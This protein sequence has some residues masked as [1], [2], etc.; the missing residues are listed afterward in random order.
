M[1]NGSS[2]HKHAALWLLA[3]NGDAAELRM[4]IARVPPQLKRSYLEFEQENATPLTIAVKRGHLKCV[5]VL[6]SAGV[7]A[8][9][10]GIDGLS[11]LH[12][13]V[14]KNSPV[15]V[16]LLVENDSVDCN[17]AD[18][19]GCTPLLV[20]AMEGF[21][22]VLDVLLH[23]GAVNVFAHE[24]QTHKDILTLARIAYN[25]AATQHQPRFKACFDLI[26]TVRAHTPSCLIYKPTLSCI[27][28][29]VW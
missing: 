25:Q 18:P 13:A 26:T 22:Q 28:I 29:S 16:R 9:H 21:V 19:H 4:A 12:L 17:V 11:A 1:G 15:I 10:M 3:R 6:L 5:N 14:K 7:D 27:C 24:L 20:A 8:N 23:C 2:T